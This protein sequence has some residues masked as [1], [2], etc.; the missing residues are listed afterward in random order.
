MDGSWVEAEHNCGF[1]LHLPSTFNQSCPLFTALLWL[2][3][4]HTRA[5]RTLLLDTCPFPGRGHLRAH[6]C[7]AQCPH[8]STAHCTHCTL[9]CFSNVHTAVQH[10]AHS[11]LLYITLLWVLSLEHSSHASVTFYCSVL[12]QHIWGFLWSSVTLQSSHLIWIV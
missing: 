3:P 10:T 1:V 9:G 2:T 4:L 6:C 5:V 12:T 8:C 7:A 11:A